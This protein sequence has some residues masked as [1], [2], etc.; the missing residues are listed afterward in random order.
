[1]NLEN[2]SEVKILKL[3]LNFNQNKQ[4]HCEVSKNCHKFRIEYSEYDKLRL[5]RYIFGAI[6]KFNTFDQPMEK[7]NWVVPFTY[8][9]FQCSASHEKFGFYIHIYSHL[10]LSETEK[11][12]KE[13]WI[14]LEKALE[15]SEGIVKEAALSKINSGNVIVHNNFPD[16][17]DRY[18]FFRE[19]SKNVIQQD[20][21]NNIYLSKKQFRYHE[22]AA[23]VAFYS[24]IEHLCTLVLAFTSS[25]MR[26]K[27]L[28]FTKL[29]WYEKYK[30]VFPLSVP[31]FKE[32]YD[33]FY[34]LSKFR[35]NPPAHG[36]VDPLFTVFS[37]YYEPA[38]HRIPVSV[39]DGKVIS[40]WHDG[41]KNLERLDAFLRLIR[42]SKQ[43][44]N[45]MKYIDGEFDISFD[46]HNLAEY[47]KITLLSD[48]KFD[49]YIYAHSAMT[50]AYANMDW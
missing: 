13:I 19:A 47:K 29:K 50:D 48:E 11:I 1:M 35:R 10:Q 49:Q 43:T 20:G 34:D 4:P 15:L 7:I 41:V 27:L 31:E 42:S 5:L 17:E 24:L 37:F 16:L 23:Y 28:S 3:L 44:K 40:K 22:E 12:F 38:K 2:L 14:I 32:F 18:L 21:S 9:E 36:F 25:D 8:K 45:I 33:Y 26:A 30:I 46:E 39:Y 6:C